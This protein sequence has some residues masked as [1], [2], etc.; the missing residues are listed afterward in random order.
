MRVF[1][2]DHSR[3]HGAGS[4]VRRDAISS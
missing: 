4:G 1:S 2:L 3:P